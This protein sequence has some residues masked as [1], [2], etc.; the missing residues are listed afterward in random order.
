MTLV[1]K[2]ELA[3]LCNKKSDLHDACKAELIKAINEAKK[4]GVYRST[5]VGTH[6]AQVDSD[7]ESEKKLERRN[8]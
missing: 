4:K 2:K 1:E 3:N 7:V 6:A 8:H 5:K